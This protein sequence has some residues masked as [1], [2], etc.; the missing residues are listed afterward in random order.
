MGRRKLIDKNALDPIAPN[1]NQLSI[2]IDA[3]RAAED[4]F[5]QSRV[6]IQQQMGFSESSAFIENLYDKFLGD[7]PWTYL[8]QFN[9]SGNDRVQPFS[10]PNDFFYVKLPDYLE[11]IADLSDLQPGNINLIYYRGDGVP[12]LD[13]LLLNSPFY[14]SRGNRS[15]ALTD[16]TPA[17]AID[18][19]ESFG[20]RPIAFEDTLVQTGLKAHMLRVMGRAYNE[21]VAPV[22]S[23]YE[24]ELE[25][26]EEFAGNTGEGN[27]FFSGD[28]DQ[29]WDGH[30]GDPSF[31]YNRYSTLS[32][33]LILETRGAN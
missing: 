15:V 13:I 28:G 20:H 1:Y 31:G 25:A 3:V 16:D 4:A 7:T 30:V 22:Y 18:Y 11:D 2:Q 12:D 9:I 32:S 10:D 8:K 19:Y 24:D 5:Y 26:Y 6:S 17:Q 23:D 14:K 33:K 29:P 27:E 21:A